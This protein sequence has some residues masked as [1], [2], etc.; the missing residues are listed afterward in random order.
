M[1][2]NGSI[3][4]AH[5]EREKEKIREEMIKRGLVIGI[6][7]GKTNHENGCMCWSCLTN[8]GPFCPF[9]E[10]HKRFCDTIA[11]SKK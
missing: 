2:E 5:K 11:A 8:P 10:E 1:I 7:T 9:P 4:Q 6:F 3:A